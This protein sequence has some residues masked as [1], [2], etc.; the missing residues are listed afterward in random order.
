M[1]IYGGIYPKHFTG[2]TS[3]RAGEEGLVPV[4][5]AGEEDYFL[6]ADGTWSPAV[7]PGGIVGPGSVADNAVVR[8]DGTTGAIIQDSPVTLSD[9]GQFEGVLSVNNTS[10]NLSL[11]TTTSGNIAIT[12]AG[13]MALSSTGNS[14]ISAANFGI[15]ATSTTT[16]DS[17]GAF[18]ID[19][20]AGITATT[21]SSNLALTTTTSG[22][23]NLTSAAAIDLSA[24][25]DIDIAAVGDV[26][27]Q[28][29]TYPAT[30]GTGG[31]FLTTDGLGNLS[32]ADAY[33]A[34][35]TV[36]DGGTG[37]QIFTDNGI[38]YGNGTNAIAATSELSDGQLLIGSTGNPPS[39][40]TLTA[41]SG[42]SITNGA[43]SITVAA[44]DAETWTNVTG[45]SQSMAINNGY[46]ANNA[47]L[48]TL[49]LPATAA[50]GSRVKLTG[51][52]AGGW[53]VAQNAGQ[54]IYFGNTT[55]T[56]GATGSIASTHQRDSV[57]LVCVAADTDWNVVSSIGVITIT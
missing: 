15:T 56:T 31:Q 35:I 37:A 4:P 33:T 8:F 22:S 26:T 18:T 50:I 10:G 20:A 48:V 57:E 21:D 49:T 43:G 3:T 2:A 29:L 52:G 28:G 7:A 13:T 19:C 16:I 12:S 45:T 54:T 5:L 55:S 9:T 25:T 30:D 32:F 40:A 38:L 46:I 17:T 23:I 39:T 34:P 47:G 27:I 41:G 24:A 14:S 36:A 11:T 53:S 1:T 51:V 6:K 44:T 42:I